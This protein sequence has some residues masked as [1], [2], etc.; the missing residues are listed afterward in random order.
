MKEQEVS[1]YMG[2]KLT[3]TRLI[4]KSYLNYV[5]PEFQVALGPEVIR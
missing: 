4:L 2:C 5:P 3:L 1:S